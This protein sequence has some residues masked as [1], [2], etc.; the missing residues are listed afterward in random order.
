MDTKSILASTTFWMIVINILLK[1]AGLFLSIDVDND[2]VTL[3]ATNI[4]SLIAFGSSFVFD[5]AAIYGRVNVKKKIKKI[6]AK[7]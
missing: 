2:T 7:P 3:A 1:V 4:A 6:G 5:A